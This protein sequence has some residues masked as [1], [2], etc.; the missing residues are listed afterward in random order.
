MLWV[1]KK[2]Y[3][4]NNSD[5]NQIKN[6]TKKE[7]KSSREKEWKENEQRVM[8]VIAREK[9][10]DVCKFWSRPSIHCANDDILNE[11]QSI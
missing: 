1:V 11:Y 6:E 9:N 7:K 4:A 2:K 5:N 3:N 10:V 8:N